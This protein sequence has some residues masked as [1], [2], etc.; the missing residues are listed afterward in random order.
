VPQGAKFLTGYRKSL[1]SSI[2]GKVFITEH[3][4]ATIAL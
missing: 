2:V 1:L 4:S 3:A